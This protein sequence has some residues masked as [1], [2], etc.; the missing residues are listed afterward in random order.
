[1]QGLPVIYWI[2]KMYKNFSFCFIIA[3]LVCNIKPLSKDTTS[4]FKLFFE[5]VERYTKGKVWSGIN[6]F[7]TIQNNYLVI[8]SINKLNKSKAAK[9]MATFDFSML[10]TK[11]PYDKLLYVLSEITD[12]A[13]KDGTNDY[14]TVYNSGGFWS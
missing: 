5:K 6:T 9:S 12:F 3:S 2:P 13:F 7:W 14:V 11:I 10:Y 8:S 4:I 1:M